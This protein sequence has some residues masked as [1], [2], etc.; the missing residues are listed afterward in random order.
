MALRRD[1]PVHS[2]SKTERIER[3]EHF[4]E[5]AE[6]KTPSTNVN[7]GPTSAANDSV[8]IVTRVVLLVFSV[9]EVMLLLRFIGKISG[10]NAA[11]PLVAWLYAFTDPLVRPFQGIFPEPQGVGT[12]VD[13]AAILSILFLLL[14]GALV[15]ALVRAI[16][17]RTVA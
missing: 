4:H 11:Q 14:I 1:D 10:A 16:A 5:P 9:L 8:T 6:A 13:I 2:D 12:V 15:V 3:I 7:V 17:G